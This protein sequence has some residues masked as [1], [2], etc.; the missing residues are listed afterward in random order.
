MNALDDEQSAD[1]IYEQLVLRSMK[2]E[3]SI[4]MTNQLKMIFE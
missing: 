2:Y 3:S 1:T 4:N